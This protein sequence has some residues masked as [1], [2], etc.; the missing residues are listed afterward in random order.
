MA[1]NTTFSMMQQLLKDAVDAS[2]TLTDVLKTALKARVDALPKFEPH[3]MTAANVAAS[4]G[5]VVDESTNS[6][7]WPI[8]PG[9]TIDWDPI[10]FATPVR[11]DGTIGAI[12]ALVGHDG[13]GPNSPVATAD[14]TL[15]YR[16]TAAGAWLAFGQTIVVDET[17]FF[18]LR[19]A[20]AAQVADVDMP[21]LHIFAE[22]L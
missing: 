6:I 4:T 21:Q 3:A 9:G 14:I 13:L 1:V 12:G 7:Q 22:Q 15:Q 16:L 2:A 17:S 18:Q 10:T 5:A 20:V 19:A 11:I 8:G